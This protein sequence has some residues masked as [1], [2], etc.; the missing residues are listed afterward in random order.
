MNLFG[1]QRRLA[2]DMRRGLP[3]GRVQVGQSMAG[4]IEALDPLAEESYLRALEFW[5]VNRGADLEKAIGFL[6]E[7]VDLEPEFAQALA[8]RVPY[9]V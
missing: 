8:L 3:L 1:L 2:R 7:A 5:H 9:R 4:G 6:D